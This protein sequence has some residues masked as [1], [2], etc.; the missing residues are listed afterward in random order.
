MLVFQLHAITLSQNQGQNA[1]S[2][3]CAL[4]Y[5]HAMALQ[6]NAGSPQRDSSA[7]SAVY[8]IIV[9]QEQAP[10]QKI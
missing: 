9:V 8:D 2:P 10:S 7:P 5:C 4:D 1:E 3:L 6:H